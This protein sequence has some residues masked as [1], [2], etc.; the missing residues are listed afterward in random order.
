MNALNYFHQVCGLVNASAMFNADPSPKL[1]REIFNSLS[2]AI[3]SGASCS[4][5]HVFRECLTV[6]RIKLLSEW[7][8]G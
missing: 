2:F 1:F 8:D 3:A 5:G 6:A 4:V 7:S